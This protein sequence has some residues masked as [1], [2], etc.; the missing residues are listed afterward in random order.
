MKKIY[1]KKVL[2]KTLANLLIPYLTTVLNERK[3]TYEEKNSLI[4]K[5]A[6]FVACEMIEGDYLEFGVYQG[7]SYIKAYHALKKQFE[8]RMSLHIGG[9]AEE[10]HQKTRQVIWDNMRFFA[11]DSFQGLPK[12]TP[13]D[14]GTN[15]LTQGQYAYP[16]EQFVENTTNAGMPSDKS[17]IVEGW[18]E[19]ICIAETAQKHKLKKASI[20]W[21]D[22]D[23]YSST[24]SVL[25]FI[26][27][28]LQ[29]GTVIIFDDWFSFRGSPYLG[30]Q[31]AFN[32]WKNEHCL[33]F[34]FNEYQK[35]EWKRISFIASKIPK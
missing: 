24:K 5:A 35:E 27:P 16:V 1:I 4:L 31:K 11:F 8:D 28:F 3:N 26:I 19:D 18:F 17:V 14:S 7:A 20:I 6:R 30:V 22:A 25:K 9:D 29:D 2:G 12:L 32:E 34:S 33:E 15:D 10:M 23:L 21:I 13:E